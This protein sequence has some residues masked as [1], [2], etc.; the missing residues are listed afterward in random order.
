MKKDEEME[1]RVNGGDEDEERLRKMKKGY[2]KEMKDEEMVY[3]GD[4]K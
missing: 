3:E 2:M 4:E 1:E